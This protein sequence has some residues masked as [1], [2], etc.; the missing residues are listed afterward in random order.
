[1]GSVFSFVGDDVKDK[2]SILEK[3]HKCPNRGLNYITVK[4]MMEFETAASK[5]R[6][7]PGRPTNKTT[8]P[9]GSRTLL[10]LHRALDFIVLLMK[11][12]IEAKDEDPVSTIAQEA[13]KQS[14]SK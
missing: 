12:L 2:L 4:S 8:I 1:M 3:H 9:S 10:R 14:L 5:E 13:Y 7:E 11:G 6:L